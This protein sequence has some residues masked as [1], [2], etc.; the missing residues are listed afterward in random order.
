VY[1]NTTHAYT[2]AEVAGNTYAWVVNGG[3]IQGPS[4]SHEVTVIW[5]NTPGTGTLVVTE[6]ITATGCYVATE[7][8]NVNI[9]EW[10]YPV[11]RVS[12]V[13]A[14]YKLSNPLPIDNVTV[15]LMQGSTLL[16]TAVTNSSGYYE[17]LNVP[18]GTY[19]V[20]ASTLKPHGGV[21][22]TDAG[23]VNYW[24][25]HRT[26]I[27][28]VK[29]NAGNYYG[30]DSFI[31]ATD[32]GQI[33]GYFLNGAPLSSQGYWTFWKQQDVS[34][35]NP[36]TGLNSF[37]VDGDNTTVNYYGLCVADFNM[38]YAMPAGLKNSE[39]ISSLDLVYG[40]PVLAAPGTVIELPFHVVD[41]MN[42]GAI[43]MIL[44]FPAEF[45]SI[46]GVSLAEEWMEAGM[47]PA[48]YNV[49]D[50]E[51]RIAWNDQLP[52]ELSESGELLK[53]RIRL[54]S[55]FTSGNTFA[56]SLVEDP[57]NE[58]ADAL[59]QPIENAVLSTRTIESSTTGTGDMNEDATSLTCYP[60]PFFDMLNIRYSLAH[61]SQVW[62]EV[63]NMY[64]ERVTVIVNESQPAGDYKVKLDEVYLNPGI[65]TLTLRAKSGGNQYIR[66][67]KIVRGW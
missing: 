39:G 66:T 64:G 36:P 33:R 44:N 4:D 18:D 28:R 8:Y 35:A 13:Y 19:W 50:N 32:A 56:F 46:E 52:L 6:T 58:L 15:N 11:Y 5:G 51:L 20:D 10:E 34:D 60:N 26:P 61:D 53:V 63:V 21:N 62:L 40:E 24:W 1:V 7:T 22:A 47:A 14:Y 31:N 37:T 43:S 41:A 17:F 27:E 9:S 48:E 23:Q 65:Y 29:W 57:L 30:T 42:V 12:G 55:A 67:T 45:A 16:A 49:T 54:S 25:T 3:L 38:S 59:Y 2:T